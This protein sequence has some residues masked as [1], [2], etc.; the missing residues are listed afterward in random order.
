MPRGD[1][2]H[3]SARS[4]RLLPSGEAILPAQR[5]R[6]ARDRDPYYQRRTTA[7]GLL[8]SRSIPRLRPC[9]DGTV[10]AHLTSTSPRIRVL[11]TRRWPR[12]KAMAD[13]LLYHPQHQVLVCRRH[14]YAVDNSGNLTKT[15]AVSCQNTALGRPPGY[16]WR[17][18][19]LNSTTRQ[20]SKLE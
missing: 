11:A 2:N 17:P 13:W 9:C 18:P 4:E 8:T 10:V 16:H 19:S 1:S 20:K 7:S 5:A 12:Q 15:P 14:G 3:Q 6:G